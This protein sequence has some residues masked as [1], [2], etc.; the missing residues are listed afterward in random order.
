MR[1]RFQ[2]A[3][4]GE[5]SRL[6]GYRS[7]VPTADPAGESSGAPPERQTGYHFCAGRSRKCVNINNAQRR[8]G[9]RQAAAGY[10]CSWPLS[11][12]ISVASALSVPIRPSILRTAGSTVVWSPPP[13]RRPISG[14]ERSV[15]VLARYIAIWRGRTTFAV[16]R[17]DKRSLRLTL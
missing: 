15:S 5:P 1:N 14:S 13:K 17:D 7:V 10:S 2:R 12:S 9:G 6:S 8:G 16:R 11:D 3:I 4:G